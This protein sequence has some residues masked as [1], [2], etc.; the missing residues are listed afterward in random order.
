MPDYSYYGTAEVSP[1]LIVVSVI[2]SLISII[3]LWR[4]YQ[5]AGEHGWAVLIPFYNLYVLFRITWGKG[6]KFWLLLIPIY[7]IILSIQTVV[8]LAKAFGKSGGFAVGLLFLSVIFYPILGFGSAHY[9]GVPG[10]AVPGYDQNRSHTT[11][12]GEPNY[13]QNNYQANTSYQSN[14]Q[15]GYQTGTSNQ[16]GYANNNYQSGGAAPAARFCPHCGMKL[17]GDSKFCPGCGERLE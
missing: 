6:S 11:N 5:K 9:C 17:P 8:K 10:M 4:I 2:V 7:N 14:Y 12:Y 16:P 15:S 13:Q 1:A 3:S